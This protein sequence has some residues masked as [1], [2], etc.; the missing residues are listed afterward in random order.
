MKKAC[1]FLL[2]RNLPDVTNKF[3]ENLLKYNSDLTDFYV[4]ESGSDDDNLTAHNT[5]HADWDDAR[6]NGLR[7]GRGFNFTAKEIIERNLD[8]EFV[9]MTTGDAH[10]PEEPVI[11]ILLEEMEK[12]PK[13]GIISPITWNWGERVSSFS[14]QQIT[15]AMNIPIPH[16]CWMFRRECI[17]DIVAGKELSVYE[18]FLYDGT[19]FRGYGIDTEL[20]MKAFSND[21]AFTV[22]SKTSHQEEYNLTDKNYVAMKTDSHN[23]HRALMWQEGLKWFKNK[24]GFNDKYGLTRMLQE[25]YKKFFERNPGMSD[26]IY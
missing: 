23:T 25:E 5:L 13:I 17:D 15:K 8:Y 19:N 22:T 11:E 18:D 4:V 26:L 12:H 9:M 2:Q 1:T 6:A 10:L 7:V 14:G 16:I 21:W 3:A 24:Y 20:M